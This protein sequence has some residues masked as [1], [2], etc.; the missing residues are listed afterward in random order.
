MK[1]LGPIPFVFVLIF[2]S[3]I[4][5]QVM[6]CCELNCFEQ[7]YQCN[8]DKSYTFNTCDKDLFECR[9]N[10]QNGKEQDFH[11]V[12]FPIGESI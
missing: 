1:S 4:H 8:I 3:P 9:V 7:K 12:Q 6:S 2:T 5:A 10:C 11:T